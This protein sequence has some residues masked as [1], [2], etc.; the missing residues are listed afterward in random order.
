MAKEW[1]LSTGM[2]NLCGKVIVVTG[3]SSGIGFAIVTL[4]ARRG[5]KVYFTTRSESKARKTQEALAGDPEIDPKNVNWLV[6]DLFDLK[7]IS[8]AT[9]ELKSRESKVDILINN[10]AA[11]TSSIE[12]VA[13]RFEQHMAANH[14]GPFLFVNRVLPLLKNALK[15]KDADVRIIN[16][17]SI[18]HLSMLPRNF[19]FQFTSPTCLSNPVPSYPWQWR[20]FGRFMFG[21]DMIRYAVSKAAVVLFTKELQR[22]LENQGLPILCIVVHPGA[23]LT[24]G[25]LAI[26]NAFIRALARRTFLTAEQ[27]AATPLFAATASEV[28]R[29]A[30]L[31]QG[32]FLVPVGKV[33]TA[34]AVAEDDRQV[35]G[36]WQNTTVEVNK[37]LAAQKLPALEAW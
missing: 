16:L 28:R 3:G 37:Q 1:D 17:G 11:S 31:Y 23:V 14:I 29:N 36:L 25:V 19:E 34:N 4:L 30:E 26:N 6:M 13:G 20:F 32:K 27:G 9:D 12:L 7:S 22:R 33:K 15:A 24:E 5:A 10:A 8:V 35:K 18:A 21:F 2:R